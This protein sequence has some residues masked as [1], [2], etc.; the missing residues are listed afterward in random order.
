MGNM[1][2]MDII[3][4]FLADGQVALLDEMRVKGVNPDQYSYNSAIHAC[5]KAKQ[6]Q[7][8]SMVL[9]RMRWV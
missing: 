3:V 2:N 8:M 7:Q 9:A 4:R 1:G 6:S 5:V